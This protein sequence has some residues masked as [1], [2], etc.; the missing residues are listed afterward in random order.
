MTGA[1]AGA[2]LAIF[3]FVLWGITPLFYQFLPDAS[4]LELLAQRIFWSIPLLLLI[5]PFIKQRT[6]WRQVLQDKRSLFICLLATSLM[7]IS[8][9]AFTYAMTHG[10]VLA[11]SLGYFI[12]PLISIVMGML[13]LSE[14][15]S[16]F[17]KI[18]VTLAA[19]GLGYQ[20]WQYGQLPS[21]ALLMASAFALYGLSRKYIRY[22]IFTALMVETLWLL[23]VAIG[24]T[25]ALD[26][27]GQSVLAS[28][29]NMT[30]VLYALS[31][32]VTLIPLFFFAAA[33]K[34]TTLTVIGLSQYF[35][36]SLQFILAVLVFHEPFDSIKA[37]SFAFIWSGLL[38]CIYQL[39]HERHQHKLK[40]LATER[41]TI[42]NHQ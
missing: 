33:I 37:V 23:P 31:A 3:S 6:T 28:S 17:Q 30:R 15:L 13:F 9:S 38:F 4:T 14:R 5:R 39:I 27:S 34:R 26:H 12:A 20:I 32:P 21:L 22:D 18:A 25:V 24:I 8:W 7:G 40:K 11:A 19:T 35:E 16:F 29:D 10:Q 36:P 42:M 41:S 1:G 2:F